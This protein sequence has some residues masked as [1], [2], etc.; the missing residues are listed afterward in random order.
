MVKIDMAKT[1]NLNEIIVAGNN[2][3]VSMKIFNKKNNY[4][5]LFALDTD[6]VNNS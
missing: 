4:I 2:E 6:E 1:L 3:V 5:S